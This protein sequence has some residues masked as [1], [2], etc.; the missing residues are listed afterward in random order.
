[1]VKPIL[2]ALV[3]PSPWLGLP[4]PWSRFHRHGRRWK[5]AWDEAAQRAIQTGDAGE[6][7]AVRDDYEAVLRGHLKMIDGYLLVSDRF[8]GGIPHP[9]F[10]ERLAETR[11]EL[12][13]HYDSLFP[14][15]QTLEDL[16]AILLA[17]VSPGHERL[18]SLAAA[19]TPPESWYDGPAARPAE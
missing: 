10:L 18:K 12:R 16:E 11:D 4:E 2:H 5:L 19:H 1:M 9:E 14:R 8:N 15:W 6:L 13:K 3:E 17:S 7:H